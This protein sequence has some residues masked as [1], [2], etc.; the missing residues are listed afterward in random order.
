MFS[1]FL[2]VLIFVHIQSP[3]RI[4]HSNFILIMN[5]NNVSSLE[6]DDSLLAEEFDQSISSP[7]KPVPYPS[8]APSNPSKNDK[9]V[10]SSSSQPSKPAPHALATRPAPQIPAP[11]SSV[12][13][14][15]DTTSTKQTAAEI[16]PYPGLSSSRTLLPP[17]TANANAPSTNLNEYSMPISTWIKLFKKWG[18]NQERSSAYAFILNKMGMNTLAKAEAVTFEELNP[19]VMNEAH[20]EAILY[21]IER[22]CDLVLDGKTSLDDVFSDSSNQDKSDDS[23]E[24]IMSTGKDLVGF[25][26]SDNKK[27][28]NKNGDDIKSSL[29]SNNNDSSKL[30]SNKTT[31]AKNIDVNSIPTASADKA[32]ANS[33]TGLSSSKDNSKSTLAYPSLG[34]IKPPAASAPQAKPVA[35]P[36]VTA[37]AIPSSSNASNDNDISDSTTAPSAPGATETQEEDESVN[38]SAAMDTSTDSVIQAQ[39][40]EVATEK[41]R[42]QTA[43]D[44]EIQLQQYADFEKKL[45]DILSGDTEKLK[46]RKEEREKRRKEREMKKYL[47]TMKNAKEQ[48]SKYENEMDSQS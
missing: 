31:S 32:P 26:S 41:L 43:K 7:K 44:I 2:L 17:S 24:M 9:T 36:T 12:K 16:R 23:S 5:N 21:V 25:S 39:N 33:M 8:L 37:N 18:F 22:T 46:R 20:S 38:E 3:L 1:V 29:N 34:P 11:A 19:F 4:P 15:S 42:E 13:Q 14:A 35:P 47:K 48:L 30:A 10:V 27:Q 28:S 6:F 45:A 40:A